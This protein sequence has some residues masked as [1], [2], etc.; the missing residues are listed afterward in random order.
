MQNNI[1]II[2][3]SGSLRDGS[4]NTLLLQT[5]GK[6]MPAT[7]SFFLYK[8]IWDLP[9]FDDAATTPVAVTVWRN[10]LQDADAVLD[11]PSRR[12]PETAMILILFCMKGS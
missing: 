6:M 7:V 12:L 10:H 1:K 5:I 3:V 11:E 4:S 8:G 9:H 2:A